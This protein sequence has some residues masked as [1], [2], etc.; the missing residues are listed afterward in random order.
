MP[1]LAKL[2]GRVGQIEFSFDG[3]YAIGMGG[4]AIGGTFG[5]HAGPG[6]LFTKYL[7]MWGTDEKE[8]YNIY[9]EAYLFFVGYKA[10]VGKNKGEKTSKT[11]EETK[12]NEGQNNIIV[13]N[14][15][16]FRSKK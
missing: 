1:L 7:R 13:D 12:N 16:G 5:F 9:R 11:K 15:D 3:G 6:I 8:Y 2:G 10:G 4:P 14:D